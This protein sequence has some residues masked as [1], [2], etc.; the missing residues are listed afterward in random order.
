MQAIFCLFIICIYSTHHQGEI[1]ILRG[2][3]LQCVCSH[4]FWVAFLRQRVRRQIVK[5]QIVSLTNSKFNEKIVAVS[6]ML[7]MPMPVEMPNEFHYGRVCTYI[8]TCMHTYLPTYLH[9]QIHTYIHYIHTYTHI[10]PK[11]EGPGRRMMRTEWKDRM[12]RG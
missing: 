1:L 5:T 8:H 4:Y 7:C 11:G 6:I 12:K 3:Q 2:H 10:Y 9:T